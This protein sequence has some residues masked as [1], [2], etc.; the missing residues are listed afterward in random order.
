MVNPWLMLAGISMILV[1]IIPAVWWWKTRKTPVKYFAF[2]V[3]LW[4]I[5]IT[6]KVL[7]DLTISPSLQDYLLGYGTG[8]FVVLIGLY[9]G[10]RT[11]L[12]ESGFTYVAGLKT[13]L[14]HVTFDEAVAFGLGFGGIEAVLLGLQSFLTILMFTVMP[15]LINQIPETQ[16]EII[17]Q[18]LNQSTWIIFA[19]IL[20]RGATLLI[21]V[22][23]SILVFYAI[24]TTMKRYLLYS[25]G[26]KT[27]VDGIIP[28]LS[29][30]VG[31]ST[32]TSVY[33]MELPIA[34]LGL[35]AAGS[36]LWIKN[37]WRKLDAKGDDHV[38]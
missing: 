3:F 4:A 6:P 21:H 12:F 35:V 22:F 7:M 11:G 2:G 28:A 32:L 29:V 19:P 15:D 37:K 13:K 8:V 20:E 30:Y 25:I 5:S 9:V 17:F 1:G 34:G 36:I 23:A 24:H 10:L 31:S 18:Q 33:L 38:E 27:V 26:Y 14:K 16:R